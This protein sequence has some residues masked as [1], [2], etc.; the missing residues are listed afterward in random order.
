[1]VKIRG[2]KDVNERS[3]LIIDGHLTHLEPCILQKCIENRIDVISLP[4]HSSIITQP[5]DNGINKDFK[6][7]LKEIMID[8]S[9]DPKIRRQQLVKGIIKGIENVRKQDKIQEA[10]QKTGLYPFSK[11]VL[12]KLPHIYIQKQNSSPNKLDEIRK[13]VKQLYKKEIRKVLKDDALEELDDEDT[14]ND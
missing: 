11:H 9:A 5:C 3:L 10:W 14:T 13:M 2:T 6:R 12:D 7:G 4:A 8:S 1:M